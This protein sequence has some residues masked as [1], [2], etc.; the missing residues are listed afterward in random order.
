MKRFLFFGL[1][2]VTILMVGCTTDIDDMNNVVIDGIPRIRISGTI[3]QDYVSRVNDGGFCTGD[4]IGL[5]GVNYT[6]N[7][8]LAG[9]LFD[10]GNQVDNA[11]YT[12]NAEEWTWTSSG[13]VYYKDSKTNIDLYGYYPYANVE[14]VNAYIFEVQRDQSGANSVDGYGLSDFLWGKAANIAPSDAKVKIT[15]NHKLSCAYVILVE[16]E[17]FADGEFEALKKS[18]LVMNTSRKAEI[19]LAT[20]NVTAVGDA[21]SEGIVMK[22]NDEG[23]RAI[24]VPQTVEAGASLFSITVDGVA[25]RFKYQQGTSPFTFE[26]GKQAKFT[27]SIK[28]KVPSGDYEFTLTDCDIVDWIGDID[29]HGG[30]ARQYYVV[31]QEEPGT[32][33]A[34]LREAKKNPAKIKNL[35]IS[36]KIDATD[37][38][39]MRDSMTV[40]QALNLKESEIM[41]SHLLVVPTIDYAIS[42]LFAVPGEFVDLQASIEKFE[43]MYPN[44]PY[45]QT[46]AGHGITLSSQHE[47]L[48]HEIPYH[49]LYQS[50]NI[51]YFSFPEKVVK[52]NES[53]FH[54]CTNLSGALI[55]PDDVIEIEATAFSGC[56]NISSLT[57]P[58]GLTKISNG[59]FNSC[60]SMS[61]VLNLP[62]SII[63]IGDNAFKGCSGFTGSLHLPTN[64][65]IL[66]GSA[67]SECRGFSGD[68]IIPRTLK[69]IQN[70]TF[71]YCDGLNGQLVLHD[72]IIKLGGPY[73]YAYGPFCECSFTGELMIP[74]GVKSISQNCFRGCEFSSIQ[75]FPDELLEIGESAFEG[76]WRLGGV[77]EFPESLISIGQKAF[78]GCGILEGIVLPSELATI[79]ANTFNNCYYISKITCKAIEPPTILSGAFNGVAKDN[80]TVEVPEQSVNRYQNDT[81]W[82]EFKRI[83]AHYDFSISRKEMR[84]LNAEHSR[85]FVLRASANYAWSIESKPDWCTITPSS[86]VGK[87]N[88]VVTVREM[89]DSDVATF[90]INT[91]AYNSPKYETHNGRAGEIVFLLNDKNYRTT[92]KVEQYDCDNYDGEVITNQ[93]ASVGNGVNIVFMGDCFDARDIANGSYLKG[94]N[95]AIGYYFDIEPY[96]TYKPYFNIYTVVGM[97]N[98]SGMGTVNTIRD[99]KFGSQYSLDGISPNHEITYE[100]AMKAATVNEDNLGQTL[101]VMIENTTEYGG[102]CYMWGDG[103]A[104]ACCPMS[105]DAYPYDFRGIVQHESGGHGFGKLADEYIYT[106]GFVSACSCPNKHLG[107][108]NACKSFGWYRNLESVGDMEKVGWSHLIFNPKYSNIVDIYEGGYFHSRG[109]FRSEPNSCMNNNIPYYSAI[110]RQEMVERI[111]R[112]A[113]K[114]FDINEFYAKDV[115]DSQ[116]NNTGATR[117]SVAETAITLTGAGKQMPPKFMGDKPQLKKSNK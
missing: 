91:G 96:K 66:G 80:F 95:E 46:I 19:D 97:S 25:Y 94:V 72:E 49:A 36:G 77:L 21:E 37:F 86:G 117:S 106:N 59:A 26:S 63:E 53:A 47:N 50:K 12:F 10:E 44:Y 11:R 18:V 67:F 71:Y 64:L 8:T 93:P 101:V 48:I 45:R 113:G 107:D 27:I 84:V 92:L 89:T 108:F 74:R 31:H 1:S 32:L 68:L 105:D 29:T 40:L 104:I 17:G 83:G 15:F 75:K 90:E 78:S 98:D 111:M 88:V 56:S 81:K 52:I 60:S 87:Q 35:K 42:P 73:N 55:I 22:S 100:Y 57:L 115:L 5:F 6:N 39:F 4:Q 9:T 112:Y 24:V 103:S 109:I 33:S 38:Q 85:E 28:K 20:G 99:A 3:D 61:G 16:D 30:E 54:N 82:G 7:N 2:C 58:Y 23:Y 110:S 51:V 69:E 13:G 43:K 116:G 41:P 14:S 79:K 114:E 70:G 65:S 76:C 34:K 62:N 102:I